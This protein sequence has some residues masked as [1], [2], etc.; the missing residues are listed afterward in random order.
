MEMNECVCACVCVHVCVRVRVCVRVCNKITLN[1]N[2]HQTE[3][4]LCQTTTKV[5][6]SKLPLKRSYLKVNQCNSFKCS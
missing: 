6:N 5:L 1:K 2:Y 4:K 3:F